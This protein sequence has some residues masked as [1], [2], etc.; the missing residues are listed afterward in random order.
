MYSP[1]AFPRPKM[2]NPSKRA[3]E[4]K[5]CVSNVVRGWRENRR[6]MVSSD[7][8]GTTRTCL[9][10][11]L[12]VI[13]GCVGNTA[14][15]QP[16]PGAWEPVVRVGAS[17]TGQIRIPDA[18]GF[19][20]DF[21]GVLPKETAAAVE[22]AITELDAKTRGQIAVVIL[23]SL[24]GHFPLRVAQEIGQRWG[25]GHA[26]ADDDST[27]NAGVVMLVAPTEKEIRIVADK[28]AAVFLDGPVVGR[29]IEEVMLPHF[30]RRDYALA[31]HCGVSAIA[32]AFAARFNTKLEAPRPNCASKPGDR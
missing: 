20:N 32:E 22:Q 23:P 31:V 4:W 1:L 14:Q 18:V 29:I 30:Q 12:L 16:V 7:S 24:Q 10:L 28:M 15:Q 11:C 26:G 13:L 6:V 5:G 2:Q 19:V 3:T 8:P 25:V 17:D 9:S 27:A 21:A